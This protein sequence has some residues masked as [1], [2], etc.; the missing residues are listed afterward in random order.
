MIQ[1]RTDA[2]ARVSDLLQ[3]SRETRGRDY[4]VSVTADDILHP[5][6]EANVITTEPEVIESKSQFCVMDSAR[7]GPAT[8]HDIATQREI[9][10]ALPDGKESLFIVPPIPYGKLTDYINYH[11]SEL[12]GSVQQAV[13]SKLFVTVDTNK[14]LKLATTEAEGSISIKSLLEEPDAEHAK[15]LLTPASQISINEGEAD[16]VVDKLFDPIFSR[17]GLSFDLSG[18]ESTNL[19]HLFAW[20]SS[21]ITTSYWRS[22][23]KNLTV[24]YMNPNNSVRPTH[25]ISTE[26]VQEKIEYPNNMPGNL[27]ALIDNAK[28]VFMSAGALDSNKARLRF[29]KVAGKNKA[30]AERINFDSQMIVDAIDQALSSGESMEEAI[31]QALIAMR[32]DN[33]PASIAKQFAKASQTP[34]SLKLMNGNKPSDSEKPYFSGQAMMTVLT[35]ETVSKDGC[36]VM[37]PINGRVESLMFLASIPDDKTLP[38]MIAGGKKGEYTYNGNVLL[39][40]VDDIR[41]H[42]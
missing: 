34:N 20:T 22:K 17:Y 4:D 25:L 23:G 32:N 13:A 41:N 7:R 9:I 29:D 37:Q 31:V 14:E 3:M 19:S 42:D 2:I 5:L 10:E 27:V 30:G 12:P 39:G 35:Q 1:E 21:V 38:L 24:A 15:I 33:T 28:K 40:I 18:S 8:S 26:A 36:L 6:I 16:E 11:L